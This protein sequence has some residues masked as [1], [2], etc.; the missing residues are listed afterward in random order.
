MKHH[1]LR[2]ALLIGCAAIFSFGSARAATI[3]V[4]VGATGLTYTPQDVQIQVGDTVQWVWDDTFHSVTSG[5]PGHPDGLF[6]SGILSTGA[7]F[8][9]TFTN[10]GTFN[11][12]CSPH[13][14]CCGMI[15]SVTVTAG[16]DT[17]TVTRAIYDSA[18]MQVTINATDSMDTAT[19]TA[20]VTQTGEVLG[21]LSNKGGG[22]YLGKFK[23]VL[24]NPR[25]VTVTSDMGGSAIAKVKAR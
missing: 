11:Y 15:G 4:Q 13:G 10:P 6:D 18:R 12:Y 23:N 19:L 20:T 9:F 25:K 14:I 7:T 8:S 16:I 5:T 1:L 3:Q 2:F 17:V 22:V 24:T 21:V